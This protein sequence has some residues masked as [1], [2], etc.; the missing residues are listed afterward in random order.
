LKK[1]KIKKII[2]GTEVGFSSIEREIIKFN[3]CKNYLLW[4]DLD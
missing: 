2:I 1:F 3:L 4:S